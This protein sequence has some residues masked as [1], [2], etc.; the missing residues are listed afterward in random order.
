MK[1]RTD[2]GRH[3]LA[4]T[5]AAEATA[6]VEWQVAPKRAEGREYRPALIVSK[7]DGTHRR[8]FRD[9]V[10]DLN[11]F[12]V[13]AL[14]ADPAVGRL[15]VPT[16]LPWPRRARTLDTAHRPP[17]DR[18]DVTSGPASEWAVNA[19][20]GVRGIAGPATDEGLPASL[21]RPEG[22]A[23][24]E[25]TGEPILWV[26]DAGNHVIRAVDLNA[27]TITTVVGSSGVAGDDIDATYPAARALLNG[28]AA[29]AVGPSG[30]LYIAD[31]DNQ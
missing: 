27:E 8:P 9:A 17:S 23:L 20:A 26:A 30:R 5:V 29:V 4:R 2:E 31:T 14:E 1:L 10:R 18:V 11:H 6:L 21:S 28:P 12:A 19:V 7:R 24:D 15:G 13:I 16:L 3:D 22:L 25:G